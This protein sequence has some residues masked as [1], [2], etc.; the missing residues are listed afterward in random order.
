MDPDALLTLPESLD[1]YD[2]SQCVVPYDRPFTWS[3]SV[4]SLD[5]YISFL[6]ENA[7]SGK[8]VALG[9]LADV[10]GGQNDWWLLNVGWAMADAVLG[11]G[12]ILRSEKDIKFVP[13]FEP[14]TQYRVS[15]GMAPQPINVIMSGSGD[16]NMLHPLLMDPSIHV[17]I[18]TTPKGYRKIASI[19]GYDSTQHSPSTTSLSSDPLS[20]SSIPVSLLPPNTSIEVV[21]DDQDNTLIDSEGHNAML[22]ILRD[23]YNIKYLDVSAGGI[24]IGNFVAYKL[25]DE[26]RITI[27]GQLLGSKSAKGEH[28]PGLMTLPSSMS[29]NP[30]SSPLINFEKIKTHPPHH[31][32]VRGRI[33]YRH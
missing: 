1:F 26:M 33:M 24:V 15:R 29:F 28:R 6:E 32:F 18:I 19:V 13:M 21:G 5:G 31:I 10:V 23:K 12:S 7:M 2:L 22:K 27:S 30:S 4:E 25:L 14:M 3:M 11:S 16:L 8:E 9:H 17:I 20:S